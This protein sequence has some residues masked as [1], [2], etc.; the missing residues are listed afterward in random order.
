L[1]SESGAEIEK[2]SSF[3]QALPRELILYFFIIEIMLAFVKAL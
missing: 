3:L 1:E 2:N